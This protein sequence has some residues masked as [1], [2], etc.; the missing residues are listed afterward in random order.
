[1]SFSLPNQAVPPAPA[2]STPPPM[3]GDGS[4]PTK[5]T[6]T[7]NVPMLPATLMGGGNAPAIGKSTL[8]GMK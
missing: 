1:M 8:M 4:T 6:G 2:A 5:K 7:G 3:F